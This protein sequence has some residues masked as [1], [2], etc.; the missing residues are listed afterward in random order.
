MQMLLEEASFL[1]EEKNV[2]YGNKTR[3]LHLT[4]VEDLKELKAAGMSDDVLKALI[5][6]SSRDSSDIERDR[7]H[8]VLRDM[9]IVIIP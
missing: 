1:K 2:V 3:P 8:T 5:I 4:T 9:G 7:A 6:Y